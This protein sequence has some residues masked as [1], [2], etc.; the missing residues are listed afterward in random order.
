MESSLL[1][2]LSR[3]KSFTCLTQT[4][5]R[6][7][8]RNAFWENVHKQ[9]IFLFHPSNVYFHSINYVVFCFYLHMELLLLPCV[10]YDL[11]KNRFKKIS[12]YDIPTK[13]FSVQHNRYMNN[14]FGA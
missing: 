12:K 9:V 6:H 7:E 3:T 1:V 13:P 2:N 5:S 11:V 4:H 8:D 14:E 10:V